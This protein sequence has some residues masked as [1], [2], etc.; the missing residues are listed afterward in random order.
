MSVIIVGNCRSAFG[1][2]ILH[3]NCQTLLSKVKLKRLFV[4]G[5]DTFKLSDVISGG[6]VTSHLRGSGVW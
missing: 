4:G 5:K 3:S 6:L 1:A 2:S